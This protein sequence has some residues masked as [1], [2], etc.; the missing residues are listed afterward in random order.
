MITSFVPLA[1]NATEGTAQC[2]ASKIIKEKL[3]T[4]EGT[5]KVSHALYTIF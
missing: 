3:S 4:K 1:S 5:T 2:F